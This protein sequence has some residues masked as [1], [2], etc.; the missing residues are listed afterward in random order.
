M[1]LLDALTSTSEITVKSKLDA[2]YTRT[3]HEVMV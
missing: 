3:E 1:I 2:V